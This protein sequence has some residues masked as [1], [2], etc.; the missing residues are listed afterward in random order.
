MGKSI[1]L[2]PSTQDKNV[3]VGN[4]G[5]E[6]K[7]MNQITDIIERIL[8][9]HGIRVYRNSPAMSLQQVVADSNTKKPDFHF[10]IHS[11]AGGGR[12]CEV[13]CHKFGGDGE[14]FARL[15][16]S[17]LSQLTPTNDRGV[18]QGY[19]LYNGQPMYELAYT[20]APASLIEIAF[21]DN[22]EDANWIIN[23]MNDIA[24]SLAKSILEYF[25]IT[26][27]QPASTSQILKKGS[28][29][30]LVKVLQIK[31]NSFIESLKLNVDGDF[32]GL[33]EN[34]VMLYQQ[35]RGLEIDGVAGPQTQKLLGM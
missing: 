33:T 16:Y 20:N 7:R 17:R 26:Y 19:K 21:H 32:G 25:G 22:S 31:L 14:K 30:E 35:H 28:N 6:E 11:N 18:M 4:Y 27:N 34:I 10:A 13:Y 5:T 1:F 29:G 2:S 8:K 15:V 3:G 23:H 9:E 24:L 12:G